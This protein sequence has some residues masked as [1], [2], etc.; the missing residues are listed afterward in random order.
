[1][2]HIFIALCILMF[3]TVVFAKSYSVLKY[4]ITAGTLIPNNQQADVAGTVFNAVFKAVG[5]CHKGSLIKVVPHANNIYLVRNKKGK[6]LYGKWSEDWY[7]EAC[8][9]NVKVPVYLDQNTKYLKY[10]VKSGIVE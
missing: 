1:M 4:P 8:E 7:I 6:V 3:G 9:V 10:D 2:R 5:K